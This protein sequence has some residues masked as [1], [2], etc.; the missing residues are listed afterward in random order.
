MNLK[1]AIGIL[2][3]TGISVSHC[4]ANESANTCI[5]GTPKSSQSYNA[6]KWYRDSAE[7]TA[8][9]R[10]TYTIGLEKVSA[11]VQKNKL[12]N[13]KW[14]VILDIDETVLDNSL[15]EKD[16]VDNCS[17]YNPKTMYPFMEKK[18]SIAT[19]GSV[20]F[21]CSVQKMGG[22]V[23]LVTNRDGTFDDK[24]QQ[25]TIDN[26]KSEGLCFDNVVFANGDKD[27]NKTPRFEAV[28]AGNYTGIVAQKN[29][30][31]GFKVIA[32]FGDNIQDFPNSK[33]SDISQ[34]SPDDKYFDKLGQE[35]FSIPNP[36]YGSWERNDFK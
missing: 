30:L 4:Y 1:R 12:Q 13:N 23:V 20:K 29:N 33:Q 15:Y 36:T 22:K 32:Y 28:A 6:V 18:V 3:M 24:I 9:Y 7:R 34:L 26:L 27:H 14:G 2:A 10:Q 16:H 25:A 8:L 21:T 5:I 19:P 11:M 35:Y 17:N 31:P